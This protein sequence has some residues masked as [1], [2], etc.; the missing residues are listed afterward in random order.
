MRTV[1]H[2]KV[3]AFRFYIFFNLMHIDQMRLMHP[4]KAQVFQHLFIF[5]QRFGD[6][7]F[8]FVCKVESRI[9]SARFTTNNIMDFCY[10]NL[11]NVCKANFRGPLRSFTVSKSK[12]I[13][14]CESVLF[15][16]NLATAC[17]SSSGLMGFKR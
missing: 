9:V 1:L 12:S 6:Q 15:S 3:A 2:H 13:L 10:L 8:L 14:S 5:L 11:S 4:C 16:F 7:Q 17:C